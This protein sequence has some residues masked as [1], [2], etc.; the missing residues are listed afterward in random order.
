MS[1]GIDY[2]MGQSN[3]DI[4]TGIRYGVISPHSVS[5]EALDEIYMQGDNLTHAAVRDDIKRV[6]DA[7]A[8]I[9]RDCVSERYRQDII[10]TTADAIIES[11][12][13]S[14]HLDGDGDDTYR[15]D[16][17]GYVIEA[18]SLGLF[19]TKS[20]Y[21][22]RARFCSPCAP[23]AGDLDSPDA[24]GVETYCLGADWFEDGEAPYPIEN[25]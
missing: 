15:Y 6:A 11:A 22:T 1:A 9:L 7:L 20:P 18:S 2:G 25:V 24:D 3:R 17:D 13:D 4:Q 19:V 8:D 5:P 21:K 23:G 14:G 12:N 16:R 10:D